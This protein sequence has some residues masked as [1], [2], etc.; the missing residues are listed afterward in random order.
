MDTGILMIKDNYRPEAVVYNAIVFFAARL[1]WLYEQ[2][3]TAP[4][5][6]AVLGDYV[7]R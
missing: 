5:I 7:Q 3:K 2:K 6:E 1:H 4:D